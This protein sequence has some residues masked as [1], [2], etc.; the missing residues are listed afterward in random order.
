MGI[1]VR[2]GSP[3]SLNLAEPVW[4]QLVGLQLSP[5]DLAEVDR[6]Y[7]PGL[8]CLRDDPALAA[9]EL[10]FSTPSAAGHEVPLS[11]T[12]RRVTDANKT[13]YIR[14][15]L[16][17]RCVLRENL[18]DCRVVVRMLDRDFRHGCSN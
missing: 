6:D 18:H 4:K 15:A 12:Y 10:P 1:A 3:L 9:L 13:E 8:L 14:A 7:L 5:S 2:T 17:Y 11:G 16:N